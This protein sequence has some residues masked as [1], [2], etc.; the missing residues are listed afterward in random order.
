MEASLRAEDLSSAFCSMSTLITETKTT[1]TDV[2]TK[3]QRTYRDLIR[4]PKSAVGVY[5]NGEDEWEKYINEEWEQPCVVRTFFDKSEY[6][7]KY[8][9]Q[10]FQSRAAFGIAVRGH[11]FG[12]GKERAVRRVREINHAG[13]FVGPPL[14]GKETLFL[15]DLKYHDVKAFHKSFCK[16]QQLAQRWAVSFNRKLLS[17]P[18]INRLALPTIQFLEC[19]VMMCTNENGEKIGILV[20]KMLD[21][22]QYKKWNTNNGY[23]RSETSESDCCFRFKDNEDECSFSVQDIPQ[24]YSHYTYLASGRK[25]LIC[26]LQGVLDSKKSVPTFE[27]TDP[28]IHYRERTDRVDFGRTDRG[29][30][31]IQDFL[32]THKCSNLCRMICRRWIKDPLEKEVM[33][34]K[35]LLHNSNVVQ[36]ET[37]SPEKKKKRVKFNF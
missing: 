2:Y 34:Y 5:I 15:E 24:A 10:T 13:E 23:V 30:D 12:E 36:E 32:R 22:T 3:K 11:I 7:W 20:E 33:H 21:H 14:V 19:W 8:S 26:D 37:I 25:F 6:C 4:E 29:K 17:L 35:D 16:T 1:M 28:A 31:G 18:G 27:L 9:E